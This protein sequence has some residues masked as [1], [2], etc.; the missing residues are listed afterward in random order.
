M[1]VFVIYRLV[2]ECKQEPEHL[3]AA[4]APIATLQLTRSQRRV[5]LPLRRQGHHEYAVD[6]TVQAAEPKYGQPLPT[7]GTYENPAVAMPL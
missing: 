5:P 2:W 4:V 3:P 6:V 1:L 7:S